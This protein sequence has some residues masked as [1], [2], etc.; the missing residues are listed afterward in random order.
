M[1]Y[2]LR[3]SALPAHIAAG[4]LR[5]IDRLPSKDAPCH[6]DLHSGNVIMTD[7]GPKLIDWTGAVR[8]P[9]VLD[10]GISHIVLSELAPQLV[11]DPERPRAVNAAI[12][13]E[14]ARLTGI[15]HAALEAAMEPHLSIARVFDLLGGAWH[16]QRESLIEQVEAALRLED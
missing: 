16:G 14:Y 1:D 15:S 4:T 11:D 9:A 12:Q 5:L 13:S 10:L 6:A 8:A 7:N 2:S 3:G